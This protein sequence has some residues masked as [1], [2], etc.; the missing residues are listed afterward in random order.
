LRTKLGQRSFTLKTSEYEQNFIDIKTI[1][2][3]RFG[4]IAKAVENKS[5]ETFSVY[6]I[7][8]SEDQGKNVS[9]EELQAVTT[10]K[11]EFF[12]EFHKSWIEEN[13]YVKRGYKIHP[14]FGSRSGCQDFGSR[15]GNQDFYPNKLLILYIQ[16]EPCFKT[17]E[18]VNQKLD[19]ELNRIPSEVMNFVG[20]FV[21]SQLFIELLEGIDYLHKQ[22][23][24]HKNLEPANI[25]ASHGLNGRFIKLAHFGSEVIQ[26]II[27]QSH[28]RGSTTDRY[29]TS[30]VVR[31]RNHDSKSDI[32]ILGI[33]IQE[34]F[35]IDIE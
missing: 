2:K 24:I 9:A 20:Y 31:G 23:I 8:L 14:D 26:K 28:T 29:V 32:Y 34:I 10:N 13:D 4:T 16:M 12:I 22:N 27:S 11:S 3:G 25:L 21:S 6:K 5:N 19:Y 1:F 33:I 17:L 7:P 15:S 35:K 30:G 18:Q